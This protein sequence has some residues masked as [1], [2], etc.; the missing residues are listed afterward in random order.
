MT[1][2]TLHHFTTLLLLK[3]DDDNL[4]LRKHQVLATID[5][6]SQYTNSNDQSSRKV[7]MTFLQYPQ[8][9]QLIIA[10]L[11]ASMAPSI[12]TKMVGL[13]SLSLIYDSVLRH[14][15]LLT[16]KPK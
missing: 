12:P 16:L 5:V 4:M 11:L 10:W 1:S 9:D 13:R 15:M 8:Q 14:I 7:S 3:L 6:S 2:P